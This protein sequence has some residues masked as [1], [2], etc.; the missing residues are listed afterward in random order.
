MKI[1]YYQDYLL[2]FTTW[3]WVPVAE[4]TLS[5]AIKHGEAEPLAKSFTPTD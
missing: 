1:Y 3:Q 4:D 5:Y 2:F